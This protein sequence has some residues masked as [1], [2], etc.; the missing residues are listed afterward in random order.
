MS[1]S[2]TL[3]REGVGDPEKVTSC[4]SQHPRHRRVGHHPVPQLH[5]V[6]DAL[7][8][9][10][11]GAEGRSW[12]TLADRGYGRAPETRQTKGTPP[13]DLPDCREVAA[14]GVPGAGFAG[15]LCAAPLIDGL[16]NHSAPAIGCERC[17]T[18]VVP[19][20]S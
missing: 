17:S 8:L 3:L 16:F 4:A 19:P 11:L 10:S 20:R 7:D 2:C 1:A 18:V 15:G 6:H 5:G 13:S 12:R 14:R 9:Q